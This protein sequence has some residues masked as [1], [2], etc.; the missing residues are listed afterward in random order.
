M[1]LIR[2]G[3]RR[4]F[5]P[6][7]REHLLAEYRGGGLT[8]REFA[9]RHGVSVSS[10]VFWLRKHRRGL[11]TAVRPAWIALPASLPAVTSSQR[12]YAI[13][14]RGGQRLEIAPGFERQ[15]V[16]HLCQILRQP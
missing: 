8:Q 16:E 10:L 5:S 3:R 12:T 2:R 11:S 9:S 13:D 14:F 6:A 4:R 7:E 15:E 1:E